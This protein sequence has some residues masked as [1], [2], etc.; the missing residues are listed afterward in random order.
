[1]SKFSDFTTGS[2]AR[3]DDFFFRKA[4][5]D[6]LW[7]S[8]RKEHVL[9]LAPRRMGKTSVMLRLQDEPRGDR[10]VV[11]L[12]VEEIHTPAEFCQAL[13]T[14]IHEQ[15]PEYLRQ[16]LAKAWGFLTGIFKG[17]EEVEVFEFKV[18]L[19]ESDPNWEQ[20]WKL[21]ADELVDR[22]RR[23][24]QELLII[25][26]EVPDMVLNMHK[27]SPEKLDAFLHWFR[28]VRQN[29]RQ[30]NIRWLIG[31]SVN[32]RGTLDQR[33]KLNLI[34]DLRV[35]PLP[36]FTDEEVAEFM[37][38]MLTMR[39]VPFQPEVVHRAK[40]LLGKPIPLFLQLLT[41]ELYRDWR[42]H[43][44]HFV[45]ITSTRSSSGF[46]SG[47]SRGTSCSTF[48]RG[49]TSTIPMTKKMPRSSCWT[50]SVAATI[51]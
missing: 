46:C 25:L 31:G 16:S 40:E 34:N 7:D 37:T 18:S 2:P 11:F 24:K 6:D 29:P 49:S 48:V 26:D 27:T 8:L 22:I 32:L 47:K 51:R 36:A 50:C 9:I 42:K 1:M 12:N 33:G 17:I 44:K 35:E 3:E 23:A 15:Q 28:G 20:N 30:D 41:Q 10:L 4:F 45:P 13:I 21:K 19:R 38:T 14:A 43:R 5:I 39:D